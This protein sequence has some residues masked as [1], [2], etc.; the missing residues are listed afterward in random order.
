MLMLKVTTVRVIL[1]RKS[2]SIDLATL[3]YDFI[4]MSYGE[5]AKWVHY[6]VIELL[7]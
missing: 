3:R 7:N 5:C 4:D 6:T 1:A 2:M